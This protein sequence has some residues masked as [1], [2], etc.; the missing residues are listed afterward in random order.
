[1]T[2]P[3]RFRRKTQPPRADSLVWRAQLATAMVTKSP[4]ALERAL[5]GLPLVGDVDGRRLLPTAQ[6]NDATFGASAGVPFALEIDVDDVREAPADVGQKVDRA[7]FPEAPRLLFNVC[8]SCGAPKGVLRE[9]SYG[10]PTSPWF[11]VFFGY[12]QI[13]VVASAWGRPFGYCDASSGAVDTDDVVRIGKAD[14]NY[15]SNWMYGVPE[16]AITPHNSLSGTRVEVGPRERIG[17]RA[18]DVLHI[19]R[20]RM[21]SA[22]VSGRPGD[23]RLEER[24]PYS[25][26]WRMAFGCPRPRPELPQLASFFPVDMAATLF[27]T[28]REVKNDPY[29]GQDVFQTFLFGGT[30]NEWWQGT[31]GKA[32][33][34]QRLLGLQLDAVRRVITDAYPDL[35]F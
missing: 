1:M 14:W 27:M 4:S 8:F 10:D 6:V 13:D 31:F 3:A 29:T 33:D 34:N 2:T 32:G 12:Y 24:G 25:F 18:W 19:A 15:F 17:A 11:N 26:L 9:G 21:V 7:F 5:E 28:F 16:A 30:V 22:Y 20:A 23:A 35:G